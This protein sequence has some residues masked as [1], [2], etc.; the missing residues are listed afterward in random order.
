[1]TLL[2]LL[3]ALCKN[4]MGSLIL[5]LLIRIYITHPQILLLSHMLLIGLV[6]MILVLLQN[7]LMIGLVKLFN[8]SA[9][10]LHH[11]NHHIYIVLP[12]FLAFYHLK[13]WIIIIV[14]T[15]LA[16]LLAL[17]K[18]PMGSLILY[19]LIRIYITHPQILLLSHM[20]LIGLVIMI[21]VLLQ[22]CLMIGLVKLFNLSALTLD[23]I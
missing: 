3:L 12:L 18:N 22:N 15:L 13:L 20:L 16:L 2:A 10:T 21:L 7:C 14:M 1:M 8:L 23:R 6:I 9:L 11:L 5:Y 4:P 17:C 19:L